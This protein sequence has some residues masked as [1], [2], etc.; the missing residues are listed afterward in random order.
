MG[1]EVGVM[2]LLQSAL[3][4]TATTVGEAALTAATP[5]ATA[6]APTVSAAAS[7][8][9][10]AIQTAAPA[11]VSAAAP[12][13]QAAIPAVTQTVAPVVQ[14]AAGAAAGAAQ[15]VTQASTAVAQT[16]AE[17]AAP[18]AGAAEQTVQPVAQAATQVAG[19]VAETAQPVTSAAGD[20]A[21]TAGQTAA[22]T[23]SITG[24]Q[25]AELGLM[26]A[27][28]GVGVT[29]GALAYE[30]GQQ[31]KAARVAQARQVR[32]AG[33]QQIEDK[34]RSAMRYTARLA[35]LA[36]SGGVQMGGSVEQL[37][38]EA[39]GSVLED[40]SR[41]ASNADEAARILRRE[42]QSA[43]TAGYIGLGTGIGSGLVNAGQIA[44][45]Y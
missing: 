38:K 1:V 42:G 44:L 31:A 25:Y 33:E 10:P 18:V 22:K 28:V 43:E 32:A 24:K 39:E 35:A 30:Q 26:G 17:Q 20:V 37:S 27:S 2:A 6:A 7:V 34:T 5:A 9:A 40:S 16:V 15:P 11:A 13:A 19:G 29:Q 23:A 36:A 3:E 21:Q 14:T 4:T 45:R 41:I 12:V 8:A